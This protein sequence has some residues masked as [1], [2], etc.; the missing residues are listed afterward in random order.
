MRKRNRAH[1]KFPRAVYESP[2]KSRCKWI[3]KLIFYK[4]KLAQLF[5]NNDAKQDSSQKNNAKE[6]R[7]KESMSV[8]RPPKLSLNF[9]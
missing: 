5:I 6:D 3:V 4:F 1:T 2:A 9:C 8:D 7:E